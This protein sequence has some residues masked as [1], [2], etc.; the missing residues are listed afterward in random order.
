MHG[1]DVVTGHMKSASYAGFKDTLLMPRRDRVVLRPLMDTIDGLANVA[2]EVLP[3]RPVRND[4]ADVWDVH[5]ATLMEE[6]SIVYRWKTLQ[7]K[8]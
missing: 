8:K 2:G 5:A 1:N 4:A 3:G 7:W 6:T